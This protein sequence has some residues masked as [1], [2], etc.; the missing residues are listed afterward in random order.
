M[1]CRIVYRQHRFC[2]VPPLMKDLH[3][4]KVPGRIT[5]QIA[6]LK[7]NCVKGLAPEYL[8]D[9]AIMP[10]RRR[11]RSTTE[12]KLPVIKSRTAQVHKCSFASMGP[13]I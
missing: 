10:H 8:N 6:L 5:Y 7:Y 13:R 9:I 11:L 3:W 4:L 2:R 1:V 12:L